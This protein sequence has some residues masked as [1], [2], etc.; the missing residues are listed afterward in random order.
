MKIKKLILF[1]LIGHFFSILFASD[2]EKKFE[3][4]HWVREYYNKAIQ[5]EDRNIFL[6]YVPKFKETPSIFH[7]ELDDELYWY[8]ELNRLGDK[9]EIFYSNYTESNCIFILRTPL[10]IY[11]I[12]KVKGDYIITTEQIK[13]DYSFVNE[14]LKEGCDWSLL[15][16]KTVDKFYIRFDGDYMNI[17][18]DG[19]N[20]L[21]V[22]YCAFDEQEYNSFLEAVKYNDF[23][24][25]KYTYPR[26]ADGSCDYDGSKTTV[27]TQTAMP[28][29][30]TNVVENKTMT[31]S[32]NLKLRVGEATST[33]VLSVMSAGTK[34]KILELGKAETIDGISSNWV[35]VEVQKGAKDRDGNSIKPGTVGWCF[36]GFLE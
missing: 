3:K 30:S 2:F 18:V 35:K 22:T 24:S 13:I 12:I 5:N 15:Q 9:C 32:E 27:A 26:H 6:R 1:I 33:Q 14:Q 16:N 25:L 21:L 23:K 11:S 28:S 29:S 34:V 19:G 36:G 7:Y 31:V 20:K 17:Y 10:E 8:E 4:K